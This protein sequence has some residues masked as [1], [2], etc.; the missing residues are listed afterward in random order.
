[1]KNQ[2]MW[3]IVFFA[4]LTTT[5]A[6][7][8]D[9]TGIYTFFFNRAP[10]QA[11][12]PLIGLYNVGLGN[13][14]SFQLGIYNHNR[15]HFLGFQAGYVNIIQG[16][17]RGIQSGFVNA[18]GAN[19]SGGQLGFI[20]VNHG[21]GSGL[22][23]GFVNIQ[24]DMF[25]G[26]QLGFMNAN[27]GFVMGFQGGFVNHAH[28]V[29]GI[30]VSFVNIA[31][32]ELSGAIQTGFVNIAAQKLLGTQL[33][34]VNNLE[35]DLFGGQLGFVNITGAEMSGVQTGFVN[36]NTTLSGLQL[37]FVN[38]TDTIYSGMPIGFLSFVKKGG[39]KA[40]ELGVSELL[41]VSLAFKTGVKSF[42]TGI[43]MGVYPN[44]KNHD[45]VWGILAGSI[46]SVNHHWDFNP[47]II[48]MNPSRVNHSNLM[49]LR[50]QVG[51]QL[52]GRL[53]LLGGPSFSKLSNKSTINNYFG[54]LSGD[55]QSRTQ[56]LLTGRLAVLWHI[57]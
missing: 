36:V 13:H 15:G 1:M 20:N 42:Y 23:A 40:I 45:V 8:S 34:F 22:K 25:S 4:M 6:Q 29:L 12:Y 52:T 9:T 18:V 30:Q 53:R 44:Q 43:Q 35:R 54:W 55:D 17:L 26:I 7:R 49:A 37:G 51:Y 16:Q 41:P 28:D 39:Y 24:Q 10:H 46:L 50:L 27:N 57:N 19:F 33:G 32:G 5:Q 38:V 47:E 11:T 2:M 56:Y 31:N 3:L 21:I 48:H 14:S